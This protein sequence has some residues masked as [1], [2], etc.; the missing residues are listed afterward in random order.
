MTAQE[1][2]QP[3]G[4]GHGG[5]PLV[6]LPLFALVLNG[7]IIAAATYGYNVAFPVNILGG[8]SFVVAPLFPAA[9]AI[10]IA[11]G[12]RRYGGL[13]QG[14]AWLTAFFLLIAPIITSFVMNYLTGLLLAN[15]SDAMVT[16]AKNFYG[17]LF[18]KWRFV[19]GE[20]AARHGV[21]VARVAGLDG[22]G[23]GSSSFGPAATR[24]SSGCSAT[25]CDVIGLPLHLSHGAHPRL[26]AHRLPASASG[27][28]APLIAHSRHAAKSTLLALRRDRTGPAGRRSRRASSPKRSTA[29]ANG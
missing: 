14:A 16:N 7:A 10:V 22:Y 5:T 23:S 8:F 4:A 2:L 11:F 24:C 9:A 20:C 12:L 3:I 17:I 25:G 19:G 27:A 13:S 6:V 28:A 21:L 29:R 1:R 15:L 18:L 26:H